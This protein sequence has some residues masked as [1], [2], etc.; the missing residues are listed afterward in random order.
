VLSSAELREIWAAL[1]DD[2]YSDIVRLLML[3]GQGREEFDVRW[4]EFDFNK[5]LI[6]FPPPRTKNKLEHVVPMS[7]PVKGILKKRTRIVGRDLVFGLGN[8]GF[9]GWSKSKERLDQRML[10]ARA[11]RIR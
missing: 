11:E 7:D 4:S 3:T 1:Q 5:S 6:V 10:D 9:S 8:G 2:G